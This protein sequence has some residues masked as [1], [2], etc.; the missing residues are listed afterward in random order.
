MILPWDLHLLR[1]IN[2]EWASPVLDRLLPVVSNV[3]T[4]IPLMVVAVLVVAIRGGRRGWLML[5]CIAV[6]LGIGDGIIQSSM[7]K[8]VSRPRPCDSVEGVLIRE[9]DRKKEGLDKLLAPPRIKPG[10]VIVSQEGRSF[11]SSHTANLFALATVVALFHRRWGVVLFV[12]AGVVGYSRVYCGAHWPSDIPPSAGLGMLI[13]WS[14]TLL[15]SRLAHKR[16]WVDAAMVP[17]AVCKTNRE[18]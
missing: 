9:L 7:K 12:I 17:F 6:A 5:G 14:S 3:N 2:Q 8:A 4:W 16:G 15:I 11:P 18:T 13:G 1:L 10:K